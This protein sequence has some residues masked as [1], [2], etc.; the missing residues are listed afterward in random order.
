MD[1]SSETRREITAFFDD[2]ASAER[3]KTQLIDAG[4]PASSIRMVEGEG[5]G[6]AIAEDKGF[7]EMLGDFFMPADDRS[8]YAE[9][10]RRGGYVVSV[11]TSGAHTDVALSILDDEGAIDMDDR[12]SQYENEGWTAR[13]DSYDPAL[14]MAGMG[15]TPSTLGMA[16]DSSDFRASHDTLVSGRDSIG[17]VDRT[18]D[19]DL[20]TTSDYDARLSGTDNLAGDETISVVEEELNIGK[21]DVANGRVRVRSYIVETPMSEDVTLRSEHVSIERNPVN[22][23]VTPG[24]DLFRE[25]TIELDETSQ[26]AVVSKTARVVE[27]IAISKAVD[28]RTE[29]ISDT[30]RR[31]EV[32]ID[33]ERLGDATIKPL[34]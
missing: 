11:M 15:A 17:G 12:R 2:R 24:D 19:A 20:T 13:T 25:R 26:E 33:D 3:A 14:G 6:T 4:L 1:H 18:M 21:R 31:T 30:V 7:F 28:E 10:L 16:E 32:E 5:D 34:R 23:A 9:G 22:R 29:T 8:T 27:E